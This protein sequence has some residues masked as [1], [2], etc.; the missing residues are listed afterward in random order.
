MTSAFSWQNR[1]LYTS[2]SDTS[3]R[4]LKYYNVYLLNEILFSFH[5]NNVSMRDLAVKAYLFSQG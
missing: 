5:P 4:F 3:Q 1:V 2:L